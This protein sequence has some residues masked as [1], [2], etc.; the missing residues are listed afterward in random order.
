MLE[1]YRLTD[2]NGKDTRKAMVDLKEHQLSDLFSYR[3]A[4][5]VGAEAQLEALQP[6]IEEAK[7][8]IINYLAV[9]WTSTEIVNKNR[10]DIHVTFHLS[11]DWVQDIR[12][13]RGKFIKELN[14]A[15]L[16]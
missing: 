3:Q 12:E 7:E 13:L 10:G 11:E 16:E 1:K 6:A 5:F 8:E 2:K 9:R 4:Y 15:K 14:D